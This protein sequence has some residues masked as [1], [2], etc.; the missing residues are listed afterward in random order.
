MDEVKQVGIPHESP[1]DSKEELIEIIMRQTDYDKIKSRDKLEE[2][3]Y[4]LAD[5]IRDYMKP[6]K[7]TDENTGNDIP[8]TSNQILYGEFRKFLDNASLTYERNKRRTN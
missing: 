5:T 1:E 8:K 4:D 3:N 7:K 6:Y 2:F